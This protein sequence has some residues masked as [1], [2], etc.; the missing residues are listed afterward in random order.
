MLVKEGC[1]LIKSTENLFNANETTARACLYEATR[2]SGPEEKRLSDRRPHTLWGPRE[3]SG[4]YSLSAGKLS[5][6]SSRQK[7]A[8]KLG[9]NQTSPTKPGTRG[10][11]K[12]G[13][14]PRLAILL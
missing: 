1:K 8:G 2:P 3:L 12:A 10:T 11:Q 4:R 5:A 13:S 9:S 6:M 14:Q 7:S